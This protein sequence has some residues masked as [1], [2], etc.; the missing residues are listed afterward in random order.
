[1]I[2]IMQGRLSKSLT[3]KIQEFPA[4]TWQ[5]EFMLAHSIGL[6]AIEWTV[7]FKDFRANPLFDG[8]HK[9]E[10]SK[11]QAEYNISIPSVTLDCFVD[12]PIHKRNETT[13][14][15]SST[16]DLVWIAEQLQDT[17]VDILVLPIVAEGGRFNSEAL[18]SLISKLNSVEISLKALGKRIAV[19]CEFDIA[20]ISQ[21]LSGLDSETFGVNFDMGN[22]ASMGHNPKHELE[23]CEGRILNIHI[24]DRLLTG[25]TVP[26]GMGAVDFKEIASILDA[27]VYSGNMILQAARDFNQDEVEQVNSYINFCRS[28][29][30][31]DDSE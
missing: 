10:I 27:Q 26:L 12:A 8:R 24:K 18:D 6:K 19:E 14:L 30:W 2:G 20:S 22:S 23:A 29:G 11:L 21:M 1:M 16:A 13:G 31:S 25:H 9:S 17:G 5:Q 3:G 4:I 28:L 15:A 7:D